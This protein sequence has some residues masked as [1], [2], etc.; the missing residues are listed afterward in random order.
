MTAISSKTILSTLAP[1]SIIAAVCSWAPPAHAQSLVTN[2]TFDAEDYAPWWGHA[3]ENADDPTLSAMQT[4]AVTEGKLCSTITVGGENPWDV[5]LGLSDLALLPNQHY[6]VTFTA[7]SDNERKVRFKTGLGDTPYTDYFIKTFTLTSTPTV[8]DFTYLNLRD[9][10]AAQIQF[11]IGGSA[12]TVCVDDIVLEPVAAPVAQP[13]VTP[14]L[15]GNPLKAHAALVKMGV[16]VDTPTFLSRPDHNAIVAGE[17]SMIT[18]A[19]SMKM[20]LIQ[21]TEVCSTTPI[22]TPSTPGRRRTGSNSAVIRWSGT[23]RSP[24]GSAAARKI[25]TR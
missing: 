2:G 19:N 15:T 3:A 1:V 21:P 23:R 18:P 20:N 16:A 25:A 11:H 13:Y 17:F 12:G 8:V 14:S 10:P 5:I 6:H 4:L 9:D 24:P 22:R 7:S